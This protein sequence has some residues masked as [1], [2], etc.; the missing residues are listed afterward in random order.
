[1]SNARLAWVLPTDRVQGE[2]L[3]EAQIDFVEISMSADGGANYS[4]LAQVPPPTL[5]HLVSDLNP[6]TY[7]FR[8][9]VVDKD[10]RRSDDADVTASILS[11]PSALPDFTVTIE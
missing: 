9:V 6:G 7:M 10:G 4:G 11:A 1:M 2:A 5:E 3:P 8:G